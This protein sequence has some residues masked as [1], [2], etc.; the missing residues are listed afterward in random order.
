MLLHGHHLF[1]I[2]PINSP[3]HIPPWR[4]DA[5]SSH[6]YANCFATWTKVILLSERKLA[7]PKSRLETGK[8]TTLNDREGGRTGRPCPARK[9]SLRAG[10]PAGLEPACERGAG[11]RKPGAAAPQ[12]RS[13]LPTYPV[14]GCILQA[15][16]NTST[17]PNPSLGGYFI[18]ELQIFQVIA[19]IKPVISNLPVY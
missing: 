9:P 15:S 1:P 6:L 13:A 18:V 19:W 4:S 10:A 2:H 11:S 12:H 5:A 17:S 8:L 3:P 16:Q 14:S 7:G